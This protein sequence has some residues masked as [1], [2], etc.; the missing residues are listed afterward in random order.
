MADEALDYL[1]A[2][3]ITGSNPD[4]KITDELH[5]V[6]AGIESSDYNIIVPKY[7][8]YYR[9]TMVVV[10]VESGRTLTR[11]VDWQPGHIFDSASHETEWIQGGI[12][13]SILIMD[14]SLTG[15]FKLTQYQ[16]LGGKWVL[17]NDNLL[18]ILTIRT[19]DP[20]TVTYEEVSGIPEIFPAIDHNHPIEDWY[21]MGEVVVAIGQVSEAINEQTDSWLNNPPVLMEEYYLKEEVD[22]LFNVQVPAVVES[23]IASELEPINISLSNLSYTVNRGLG[24]RYTK[25]QSDNLYYRKVN[26]YTKV[27]VNDLI[28]NSSAAAYSKIESDARYA[29]KEETYTKDEVDTS[30][31]TIDG[32]NLSLA[33]LS[34]SFYSK[35]YIDGNFY[36]INVID[37]K[38]YTKEQTYTKTES[39]ERYPTTSSVNVLSAQITSLANNTY[40]KTESDGK[41]SSTT[42]F[43]SLSSQVTELSNNTYTKTEVDTMFSQLL[44]WIEENYIS[45][46]TYASATENGGLK[47]RVADG[48]LY[49]ATDGSDA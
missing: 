11:G 17:S 35:G 43:N 3:D 2:E 41:Y 44:I 22:A 10:H 33:S 8:P 36:T 18:E 1:Y 16:T 37:D 28:D 19:I 4:N 21:G 14:R 15:Q 12:Y 32:V 49:I 24:D 5:L 9:N 29:S 6:T 39:D 23:T 27:E 26:T 46:S 40:S 7:M 30:F 42:A 38:F 31:A 47:L 34:E 20:R 13:G 45:K 48:V 25:E